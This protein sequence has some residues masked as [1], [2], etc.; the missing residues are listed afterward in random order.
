MSDPLQD[1][2]EMPFVAHFADTFFAD[3]PFRPAA[4][5][6]QME[7]LHGRDYAQ[8][9]ESAIV[10]RAQML[11]VLDA[12]APVAAAIRFNDVGINV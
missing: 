1:T 7:W 10:G 3:A 11:G 2:A 8:F 4:I 9:G 6:D 12:Q 5:I